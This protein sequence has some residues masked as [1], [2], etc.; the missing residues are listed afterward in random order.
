MKVKTKYSSKKGRSGRESERGRV[1]G[2]VG[3]YAAWRQDH[4]GNGVRGTEEATNWPK[5]RV[6]A[7]ECGLAL[8]AND[9]IGADESTQTEMWQRGKEKQ[10]KEQKMNS[11]HRRLM[12]SR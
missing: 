8:V 5:E 1:W 2:S 9:L 7:S 10:E 6:A 4:R 12:R 11:S 3:D